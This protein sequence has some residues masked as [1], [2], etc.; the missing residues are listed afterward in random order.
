MR[1]LMKETL[2]QGFLGNLQIPGCTNFLIFIYTV[3]FW[4]YLTNNMLLRFLI[5]FEYAEI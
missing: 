4:I 1:F 2:M 3:I 5:I